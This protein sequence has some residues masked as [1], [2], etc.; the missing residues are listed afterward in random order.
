MKNLRKYG[1]AP[2]TVA[3]VHG[4]P[5]APGSIAPVAREL[6]LNLGTLEP[7]QTSTSIEG[8]IHELLTVLEKHGDLPI[9]LI[10]HS[11]GAWLCFIFTARHPLIVN[12]FINIAKLRHLKFHYLANKP[13]LTKQKI[14]ISLLL[15]ALLSLSILSSYSQINEIDTAVAAI[16][17]KKTKIKAF[18]LIA[19]SPETSVQF[20]G[21]AIKLFNLSKDTVKMFH[22]PSSIALIAIYTF[23]KQF[24]TQTELTIYT[25]KGL[26]TFTK[27]NYSYYPDTYFGIGN[28]ADSIFEYYTNSIFYLKGDILKTFNEKIFPGL[29]YEVRYDKIGDFEKGKKLEKDDII[30]KEGGLV[31]E[32]GP[33]LVYD[34]RDNTFF[35]VRGH[36]FKVNVAFAPNILGNDYTM[37][38]LGIDLRKYFPLG[39]EKKNVLASQLYISISSGD[40]PFYKLG[41]LGGEKR[42]RGINANRYI[43]KTMIYFQTEY[44]A[45]IKGRFG[46]VLFGGAGDM[47]D[48]VDHLSID[49]DDLKYN[50]GGGLRFMLIPDA[51]LNI[52]LDCGFANGKQYG[53]Y[54]G[55]REVF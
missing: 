19:T 45:R 55:L 24:L 38:W 2:F 1:T 28:D 26:N 6:S 9:T 37:N 16:S 36:Y 46:F 17:L 50:V 3:V 41:E 11:W 43:D 34:L 42:L 8:Q 44:R 47:A 5:G 4:G 13:T 32:I 40:V 51:K 15:I 33:V 27:F 48:R 14:F 49:I 52:R 10:G 31:W 35:P 29:V 18:P 22:R 21:A 12:K 25:K 54:L 39:K 20:G 7:L 30:G 23:N 53:V